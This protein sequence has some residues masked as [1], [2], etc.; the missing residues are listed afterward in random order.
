MEKF[1]E[2]IKNF[3]LLLI[4]YEYNYVEISLFSQNLLELLGPMDYIGLF[5][6]DHNPGLMYTSNHA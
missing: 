2:N 4:K 1:S 6:K 3:K 5:I